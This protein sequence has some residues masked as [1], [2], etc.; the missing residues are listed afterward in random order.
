M[1]DIWFYDFELNLLHIDSAYSSV[2]W[3]IK[4]NGIG[5]FEAHFPINSPVTK[6]CMEHSYLIAVQGENQAVITGKKA[7]SDLTLYGRTPNW[8]LSKRVTPKFSKMD[9]SPEYIAKTYVAKAMAD[10]SNFKLMRTT[11][12]T[13]NIKFWRNV[14]NPTIKVV[15]E[16]LE[17][18]NAGHKMWF[19]FNEKKIV[20]RAIKPKETGLI[21]SRTNLNAQN[22]SYTEDFQNCANGGF[23]ATTDETTGET[24]WTEIASDKTGLYRWIDVLGGDNEPDAQASLKT[25]KWEKN[26]KFDVR[27]LKYGVDYILGDIVTVK[28][29]FGGYRRSD[30]KQITEVNIWYE[31]GNSGEKPVFSDIEL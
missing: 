1:A 31:N 28:S 12:F 20:Y 13:K 22:I 26:I 23:Y 15:S 6:L 17:R 2:D 29:E 3:L 14:Y 21:I 18:V 25:R 16:C 7:A 10:V 8:F 5:T 4:F 9:N 19:D 30:K 27:G 24:T 11:G